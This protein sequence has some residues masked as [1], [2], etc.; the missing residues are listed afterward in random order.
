MKFNPC[1]IRVLFTVSFLCAGLFAHAKSAKIDQLL[2]KQ[3]AKAEK[4]IKN[5][6]VID[7]LTFLRRVSVD[8]IGRIPTYEE[9]KQFLLKQA[10][11]YPGQEKEYIEFVMKNDQA[12]EQAKSP[13]FEEKVINFILALTNI[14]TKNVS[15]DKLKKSL[16]AL[17]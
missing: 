2:A 12:K 11:Q 15:V 6:E 17:E 7:D 3:N 16:E 10:S 4:P 1:F 14:S 5:A 8:V 13:I 9:V